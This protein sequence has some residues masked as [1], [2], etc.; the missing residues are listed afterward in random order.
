MAALQAEGLA[1]SVHNAARVRAFAR[2][3]GRLAKTD[4]LNLH[5]GRGTVRTA[6]AGVQQRWAMR[7]ERISPC[8]TTRLEDVPRVRV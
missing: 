5:Y 1:V 6:T 3:Q 8:Y 7:R 4:A 2:A